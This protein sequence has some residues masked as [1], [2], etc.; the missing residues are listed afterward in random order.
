MTGVPRLL[1]HQ[2]GFLIETDSNG[3]IDIQADGGQ[4]NILGTSGDQRITFNNDATPTMQ[5]YQ[6]SNNLSLGVDTNPFR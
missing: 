3:D 2:N 6:N 5:Y 4:V 1:S